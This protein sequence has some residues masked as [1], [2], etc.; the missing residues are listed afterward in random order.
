MLPRA[1]MLAERSYELG[2]QRIDQIP[3]LDQMNERVE[4][5]CR[6]PAELPISKTAQ[7]PKCRQSAAPWSPPNFCASARAATVDTSFGSTSP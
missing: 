5:I 3:R 6:P 2:G 1:L 4:P 7:R